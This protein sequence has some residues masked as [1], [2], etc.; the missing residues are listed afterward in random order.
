MKRSGQ[1]EGGTET[2]IERE[3]DITKTALVRN[4]YHAP[5]MSCLLVGLDYADT[6]K[7]AAK[8]FT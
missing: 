4:L 6:Y 3:A 1:D 7:H 5:E 8:S 2:S